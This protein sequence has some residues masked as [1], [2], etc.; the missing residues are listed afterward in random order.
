MQKKNTHDSWVSLTLHAGALQLALIISFVVVVVCAF[1]MYYLFLS[2]RII[3]KDNELIRKI[4]SA[5]SV[6]QEA[7]ASLS[8]SETESYHIINSDSVLLTTKYWGLYPIITAH[9]P[10]GLP[11]SLAYMA[12]YKPDTSYAL[13]VAN[14][15]RYLSVS[16][17]AT[18]QGHSYVPR[19]GIRPEVIGNVG[20]TGSYGTQSES[21][22]QLPEVSFD[23]AA[24][25]QSYFNLLQGVTSPSLETGDSLCCS[26]F[27]PTKIVVV[28]DFLPSYMRGNCIIMHPE[29]I[30]IEQFHNCKDVIFIAPYIH[31]AS[32]FRGSLQAFATDSIHVSPHVVLEQA[33]VLCLFRENIDRNG[34]T[35][36]IHIQGN[37][38]VCGAM[39]INAPS[40][41]RAYP[42]IT[43]DEHATVYGDIYSHNYVELY[44]TVY[45]TVF[46]QN[47][48]TQTSRG[49]YSNLIL[50]GT[51]L[52]EQR[53][54]CFLSS[55]IHPYA[56]QR[57]LLKKLY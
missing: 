28:D 10:G 34:P 20:Y 56:T 21:N 33:S 25:I 49:A 55:A 3:D 23:I 27:E 50:H 2:S 51:I 26:F 48:F 32:G 54:Q 52:S 39:Y 35:P 22:T 45:G 24:H 30:T 1:F 36:R 11:V 19:L 41:Y 14:D 43:I 18:I 42:R 8:F 40:L 4:H 7:C 13:Y 29:K 6:L 15:E 5:E 37:A 12:G 17:K 57:R 9:V 16:G 38:I 44:G 46:T 53:P 47:L 31:I